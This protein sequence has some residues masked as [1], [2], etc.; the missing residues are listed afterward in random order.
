MT[1][2]H[3][4]V[5]KVLLIFCLACFFACKNDFLDVKPEKSLLIPKT[6]PDLRALLDNA[7]VFNQ[8][9]ALFNNADG[10]TWV[11][12]AGFNGYLLEQERSSYNWS[13]DIFGTEAAGDWNVPYQQVFYANIVLEGLDKLQADTDGASERDAIRG[14]A[15]F[16]RAFAFYNLA[17]EFTMP[18]KAA[19]AATD[20]GIPIR[21]HSDVNEK[22]GRGTVAETYAR[23]LQDLLDA[24]KLLP[25]TTDYK[26]RPGTAAALALLARVYLSM[27][28][29]P[30][31]GKY[32]D[33]CQQLSPG[34]LN[35][36]TFSATAARP[37]PRAL[38]NSNKEILFYSAALSYTFTSSASP[39]VADSLLYRSYV[40]NDLRKVL[41]FRVLAP[42]FKFKGNYAGIISYFSG[43]ATDE[44][45]LVRAECSARAGDRDAA[46]ADLNTLL[47][48]RWKAGTFVPFTA[49]TADEALL[50]VLNERRK[51]LTARGLRWGDLRRLNTEPRFA[52]TLMR[53]IRG[54]T[55]TLEPGSKRYAYPIPNQEVQSSGIPQN[56]R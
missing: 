27:A 23:V 48:T 10:D 28:D 1:R 15:L 54:N 20:A 3:Q 44:M 52:V 16:Y 32:A 43:I 25:A 33:S 12:D 47:A 21:L 13:A 29:Y 24:R 30:R 14:T 18:Y 34:L 9:P 8:S 53:K 11:N 26:T 22:V 19:T 50:L 49:N 46:M 37:F 39:T 5:Y 42:G 36:N 31:A 51:E 2:Y 17:Q 7:Q 6:L 35:Y 56:E 4:F 41:F 38:P 40:A 55:Y 45:Y